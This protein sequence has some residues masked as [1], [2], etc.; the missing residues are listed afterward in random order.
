MPGLVFFL[1]LLGCREKKK[2]PETPPK[3]VATKPAAD[4]PQQGSANLYAGVDVSPMDMCYF[5][6]DYPKLKI[7]NA[8]TGPPL[9]RVIYS[10]P[11]LQ[12]RRLFHDILKYDEPWR[13]G[14]NEA[15]EIDFYRSA[16]I[17]KSKV[18]P[19]RYILYAIPHPGAWT[20]VLNSNID[21]WGL[22]QDSTKDVHRFRIPVT[23]GNPSLEY[24][25]MMFEKTNE[26][27]DLVMAWEDVMAKLPISF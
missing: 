2:Q 12:R 13:L 10:R 14:A 18:L 19:G 7:A 22:K 23:S 5:P 26:G 15:T 27:T 6:I 1:L 3:P 25:T 20:I 21:S 9:V 24:F 4:T 17:Q 16:T 8:T 11:H